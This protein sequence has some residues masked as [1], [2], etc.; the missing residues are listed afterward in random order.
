MLKCQ[1]ALS[2]DLSLH[3]SLKTSLPSVPKCRRSHLVELISAACIGAA[4]APKH[5]RTL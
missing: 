3:P 2:Y 5:V 1:R 4:F